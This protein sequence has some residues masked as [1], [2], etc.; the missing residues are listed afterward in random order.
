MDART[1]DRSSAQPPPDLSP[2][3]AVGWLM[4]QLARHMHLAEQRM[5]LNTADMRLLWLLSDGRP[6]TLREVS[7]ALGL[8]QS[9]VNRQANA[10]LDAGLLRRF[11]E[12][13]HTARLLEPT[14]EGRS[15]LERD[16]AGA[17]GALSASLDTLGPDAETFLSLFARFVE[18]YGDAVEEL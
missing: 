6:R 16:L 17:L 4:R 12:P 8:E 2:D 14:D 13:G 10:A 18:A 3:R 1:P 5:R 15:A 11:D 9:T 7:D